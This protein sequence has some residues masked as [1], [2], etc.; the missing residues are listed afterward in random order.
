MRKVSYYMAIL[1]FLPIIISTSSKTIMG[2]T[3]E[4]P[5][6]NITSSGLEYAI[7]QK[8]NGIQAKAGDKVSLHYTGKLTNDTVFDSSRSRNQPFDFIL[9]AGQVIKGWD[10]GI[11][12][13]HVGDKAILKIP[14]EL[15]YGSKEM[16]KIPANS[17]LIFEVEL[18]SIKETSKPYDVKGLDTLK[19]AS[20][21]KYFIIEK[22]KGIKLENGMNVTLHY[23]GYFLDGKKFD[24]S[25]DRGEPIKIVLGKNQVI[26]GFEEALMMLSVGDKARAIIPYQLAYGDKGRG[27]IPPKADLIFDLQIVD[28]KNVAKVLPFDITGKVV[29]TTASGLQYVILKE[30]TGKQAFSSANVTVH[31]TG[32][33]TNGTVFDSSVEREEPI[34]FQLGVGQVIKGWD[35][36]I[37]LL[38]EGSKAR[39]IIPYQLGYGENAMGPIPAKSNLIF[40]VELLKVE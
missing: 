35:E 14:A 22:G 12:L 8:G 15:G 5:K 33:L 39:F 30:G 31:Y 27:S 37:A 1:M 24:S 25:I 28:A 34:A 6:F 17:T 32:Y 21:L 19:T 36:G 3:M 23:S 13:L 29:S 11:A 9:G 4:Q 2:Q 38:K 26:I 10:E 7:I 20:G 40:D 16:G 18:L